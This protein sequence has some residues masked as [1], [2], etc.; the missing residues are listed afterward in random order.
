MF[1]LQDSLRINPIGQGGAIN[2]ASVRLMSHG[3]V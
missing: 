1:P 3:R 2:L